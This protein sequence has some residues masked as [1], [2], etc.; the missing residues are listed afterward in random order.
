M[1]KK[2]RVSLF[3]MMLTLL[4]VC[5][6]IGLIAGCTLSSREHQTTPNVDESLP[7]LDQETPL[8]VDITTHLGDGHTF[9]EGDRFSL[10]VN[11]NQDAFLLL[12]HEDPDHNLYQIYPAPG[13][14]NGFHQA[15][16]YFPITGDNFHFTV[17]PPFGTD[18][19]WLFATL[20]P[21]PPLAGRRTQGNIM[22]LDESLM[23]IR[24]ALQHNLTLLDKNFSEA[25]IRIKTIP[26]YD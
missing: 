25:N 13:S 24:H 26:S 21:P 23:S 14:Q 20:Q 8:H 6:V 1:T 2:G 19:F 16:F 17:S 22:L 7:T 18:T 15:E 11:L 3:S 9:V 5:T 10:L 4:R 12:I